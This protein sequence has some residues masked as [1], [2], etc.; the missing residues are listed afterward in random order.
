MKQGAVP[1][2]KF[3]ATYSDGAKNGGVPRRLHFVA[4]VSAQPFR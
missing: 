2:S 1:L 3:I 4:W